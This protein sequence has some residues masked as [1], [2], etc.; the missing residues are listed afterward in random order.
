MTEIQKKARDHAESVYE[1]KNLDFLE[2][3]MGLANGNLTEYVEDTYDDSDEAQ[4]LEELS[5]DIIDEAYNKL[6]E[7]YN[8]F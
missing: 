8:K 1:H 5:Y 7:Q 3:A 6:R 2:E 4:E